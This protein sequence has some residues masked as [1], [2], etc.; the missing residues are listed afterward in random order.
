[1]KLLTVIAATTL[2]AASAI[3][4]EHTDKIRIGVSLPLTGNAATYGT[5]IRNTLLFAN[6]KL[7][8][9]RYELIFED[10]KCVAPDAVTVA[11]RFVDVLKLKYVTG[12]TCSSTILPT[13]GLYNAGGAVVVAPL[14]SAPEISKL[15]VF[16]TWPSDAGAAARLFGFIE[17]RHHTVGV[18]SE[19]TDFTQALLRA[20]EQQNGGNKVRIINENFL[21][22]ASD[23]RTPLLKLKAKNIDALF[24][25]SQTAS[26]FHAALKQI[27]SLKLAAPLYG[28]VFAGES[29]VLNEPAAEGIVYA[30]L[31]SVRDVVTPDGL[32]LFEEFKKR[33][34]GIQ[35]VE[36]AFA[37]SFEAFRA[38]HQAIE[39]GRDVREY[40]HATTFH[41]VFGD[42]RFD[43]HGDIEGLD[44]V[45]KVIHE[46]K[47]ERLQDRAS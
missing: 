32:N 18:L 21:S 30:D 2:L 16:R 33:Y 41:G 40:L 15:G 6:E 43:E 34:G 8:S 31:P 45:L 27:T 38:L 35:G 42:W 23:F 10:D 7:A 28:S 46:R 37:T 44:Y 3:A 24:I 1:M 26:T 39:S 5:D 22:D 13:S 25:N 20:F 29:V 12:F 17:A 4:Q 19:Q 36:M 47:G 14:G 11:H 9:D